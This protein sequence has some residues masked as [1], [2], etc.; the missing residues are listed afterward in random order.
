MAAAHERGGAVWL[1]RPE[2]NTPTANQAGTNQR[3]PPLTTRGVPCNRI[4]IETSQTGRDD[5][6]AIDQAGR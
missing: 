1:P 5:A 4:E 3:A 2:G 6:L